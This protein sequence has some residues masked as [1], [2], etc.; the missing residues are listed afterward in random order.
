LSE[1]RRL[2]KQMTVQTVGQ[3]RNE[4][5]V[6]LFEEEDEAVRLTL[7]NEISLWLYILAHH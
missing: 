1:Q 5:V 7:V 3:S 2:L 4:L 6:D